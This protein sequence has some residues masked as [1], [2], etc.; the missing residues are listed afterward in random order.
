M[1]HTLSPSVFNKPTAAIHIQNSYSVTER[2]LLNICLRN[3][4]HDNFQQQ[5]YEIDVAET[6][7]LLGC[8]RSKN[9]AWLKNELFKALLQK[10]IRWN[11]LKRDKKLQEWT[12]TF[13][14][15]YVVEPEEG[16]LAFQFN[17]IVVKQFQERQLY[18][19]LILQIQAPIKSGH[20]LTLYE[21]LNDELH[22]Y[23]QKL[24]ALTI[25]ISDLRALLDVRDGKYEQFKHL[26]D[27]VIKPA[28]QELGRYTDVEAT[29]T[30]VKEGRKV[31]ALAISAKRK[32][33]FQP[34]LD[35]PDPQENNLSREDI[36]QNNDAA[37]L[38]TSYG[39]TANKAQSLA[40][41]HPT[42][43]IIENLKYSLEQQKQNKVQNL[44]SYLVK[45]IEENY[46]R[47]HTTEDI[48][49]Q[50]RQSWDEHKIIAAESRFAELASEQQNTLRQN[51][52]QFIKTEPDARLIYERFRR[53]GGWQSRMV[54]H[55]FKA[56][57]LPT[58]LEGGHET[59]FEA[60]KQWWPQQEMK[61]L[62]DKARKK[63]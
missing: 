55:G 25:A 22:R 42:S 46:Q 50:L 20:T 44:P 58:L 12:C 34:Y 6:L 7:K 3:G 40:A 26:N 48:E 28:F 41:A 54:Q 63:A 29:Y 13:L 19:K 53:E 56:K 43:Q 38:L 36:S 37:T 30:L 10:T 59:C 5:M 52:L 9:T 18:S 51:Y 21:Y 24:K 2:K 39:I 15:G 31:S 61:N 33:Y 1:A 45:A 8:D 4:V 23:K 11:V 62:L 17:P 32:Q 57:V 14:S 47:S 27:R 60:F 16:K 49:Q 35:I